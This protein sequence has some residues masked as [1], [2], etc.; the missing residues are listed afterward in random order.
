MWEMNDRLRISSES[1][2]HFLVPFILEHCQ[3]IRDN[4]LLHPQTV[5]MTDTA[6]LAGLVRPATV[7]SA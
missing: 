6:N 4:L 2:T 7:A 1:H 3:K 5:K